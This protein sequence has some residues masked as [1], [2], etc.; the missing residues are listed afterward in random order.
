MR[1]DPHTPCL[2]LDLVAG[3]RTGAQ[4]QLRTRPD[5]GNY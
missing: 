3:E 4:F 2:N 5:N 1:N